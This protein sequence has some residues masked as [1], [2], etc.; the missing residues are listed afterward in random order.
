MMLHDYHLYTAPGMIREPSAPTPSSTTSSTSPGRSR[1][2]G[3]S[4]PAGSARRSSSG[5]LANDII[6]FHTH[7]YCINFLRCCD[8]LL[9]AEV[10]YDARRGPPRRRRDA[11]P[12]L[13]ALDRR[14]A[15]AAGG[16]LARGRRGRARGAGAPPQ[17][18]DHPR[19]PRRPLEE[20]AARLHRLRHLPHPAP[21]VPR[22]GHLHRPPAALAPG[23]ARV[24][25]V[26]GA[27]R[28]AGRGRQPPPRDH[29]LD[30]DRPARSTRTS[31]TP[32]PATSTSTC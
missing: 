2:A 11:G 25:R 9:E 13:P 8:E 19:R 18:P 16:G 17:A 4:C 27:D 3:G 24:R 22:R 14:R 32:S 20:R 7:A 5:M 10:D 12:R 26:P 15:A 29:R 31:P 23:R 21:R 1:T 30:A 28:G 6:G